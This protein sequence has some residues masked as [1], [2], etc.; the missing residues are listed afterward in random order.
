MSRHLPSKSP[1][2]GRA[3]G[4]ALTGALLAAAMA[5]AGVATAWAAPDSPPSGDKI[6]DRILSR[7]ER[8]QLLRAPQITGGRTAAGGGPSYES[9]LVGGQ[10]RLF[11]RYTPNKVLISGKPAPIVFVLHPDGTR[12]DQVPALTGLNRLADVDGFVAVYPQGRSARWGAAGSP[13]DATTAI[14]EDVDFLNRLADALVAQNVADPKR[15]YLA[16]VGRGGDIALKLA[17]TEGSRFS[18][19]GVVGGSGQTTGLEKCSVAPPRLTFIAGTTADDGPSAAVKPA[20][21]AA[22][23]A[24]KLGCTAPTVATA[25]GKTARSKWSGCKPGTEIE[26]VRSLERISIDKATPDLWAFFKRFAF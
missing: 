17:C 25:P 5:I 21:P 2:G 20:D 13:A 26:L 10:V 24:E 18:A 12:A 6:R 11:Q 22:M 4:A 3:V 19:Y 23:F 1:S 14:D 15:L 8:G 7:V 16:G 9:V